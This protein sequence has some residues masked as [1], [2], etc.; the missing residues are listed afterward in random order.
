MNEKQKF[1]KAGED[2]AAQ[3]LQLK[4]YTVLRRN[5]RCRAGEIDIIAER[6][7]ELFFIEVKTRR[8]T[9]FGQP[10][11]AVTETKRSHMRRAAGHF[12][13]E[14]PCHWNAFSFQVVEIGFHQI[15]DA[16]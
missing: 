6:G 8:D 10:C 12:L 9:A 2:F 4:G 3:V 16:F 5:Y 11:E 15:V 14:S 13:S 1:G 7:M